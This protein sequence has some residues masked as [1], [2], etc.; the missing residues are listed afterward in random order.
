MPVRFTIVDLNFPYNVIIGLLLINKIKVVISPH[1]LLL[2][3]EQDDGKVGI[4]K[5][6]KKAARQCLINTSKHDSVNV[7][8]SKR[9]REEEEKNQSVMS[10]YL[11][12]LNVRERPQLTEQHEEV[13]IFDGK[14]V[15]MKNL[16]ETVR[17]DVLVT[18]DEF[19]EIFAYSIEEM[20]KILP[21]KCATNMI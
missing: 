17:H 2:Q 3:F 18:I 13:E 4:L 19:Y 12:T 7:T 1:Q 8:S 5:G 21:S 10:V 9:K 20:P 11:D 16:T 14:K 6:N 15:E